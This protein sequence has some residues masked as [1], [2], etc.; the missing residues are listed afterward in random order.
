MHIHKLLRERHDPMKVAD[1]FVERRE[2]RNKNLDFDNVR[3]YHL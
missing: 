3:H 1:E 2:R